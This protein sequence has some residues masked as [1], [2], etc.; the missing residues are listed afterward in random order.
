MRTGRRGDF[1][2]LFAF[3]MDGA[4]IVTP[5]RLLKIEVP[6]MICWQ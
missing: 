4:G 1:A 6:C 3:C 5:L 2:R